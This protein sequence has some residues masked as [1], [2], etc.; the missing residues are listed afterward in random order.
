MPRKVLATTTK[1]DE[2]VDPY[3]NSDE[4]KYNPIVEVIVFIDEEVIEYED[5][6]YT[7]LE[8]IYGVWRFAY[9]QEVEPASEAEIPPF[10]DF[11]IAWNKGYIRGEAVSGA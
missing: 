6:G 9:D 10:A 1:G 3:L 7:T 2:F 5:T 4:Y 11:E 8:E